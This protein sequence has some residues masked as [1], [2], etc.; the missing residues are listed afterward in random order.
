MTPQRNHAG[1]DVKTVTE[2]QGHDTVRSTH[3]LYGH[4][5]QTISCPSSPAMTAPV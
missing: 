5:T 2:R 1:V 4:V 3:E